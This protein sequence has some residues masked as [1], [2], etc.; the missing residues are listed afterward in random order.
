MWRDRCLQMQCV[1]FDIGCIRKQGIRREPGCQLRQNVERSKMCY[2]H[3]ILVHGARN[4]LLSKK[5]KHIDR[6]DRVFHN[7]R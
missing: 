4:S 2:V 5:A 3:L 7:Q 1:V 6:F